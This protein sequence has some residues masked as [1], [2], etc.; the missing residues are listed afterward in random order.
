M[1]KNGLF[2]ICGGCNMKVVITCAY[3]S[4]IDNEI[5]FDQP[6]PKKF[7]EVLIKFNTKAWVND[8]AF[9][10]SGNFAF[11]GSHNSTLS[12]VNCREKTVETLNLT[13]SPIAKI[14][15]LNDETIIVIG[16]DRH[17]YKYSS[18][19]PEKKW[20]FMNSLTKF[21][22]NKLTSD[23]EEKKEEATSFKDRLG[24]FKNLNKKTSL[25]VT[26]N[27]SETKNIHLANICSTTVISNNLVTAD[28]AGYIKLWPL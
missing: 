7:G 20:K 28:L 2:M 22:L 25:I 16:F 15:P 5:T 18:N 8:V 10:P 1:D 4:E 11:A 21:D 24:V 9:S 19:N 23:L 14:V 3:I 12:V 27:K 6:H 26:S 17:F 13:H